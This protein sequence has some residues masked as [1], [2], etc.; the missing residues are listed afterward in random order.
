MTPTTFSHI[1]SRKL[2]GIGQNLAQDGRGERVTHKI[3]GKIAP[4]AQEKGQNTNL[5]LEEYDASFWSFSLY[6]FQ[7]NLAEIRKSVST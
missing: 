6:G 7:Q 5:F 4:G 3:F 1:T 2:D